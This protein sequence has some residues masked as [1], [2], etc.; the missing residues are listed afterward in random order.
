MSLWPICSVFPE[1]SKSEALGEI[2]GLRGMRGKIYDEASRE[3][4]QKSK[5]YEIQQTT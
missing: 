2:A 5:L 4:N 1:V 3:H